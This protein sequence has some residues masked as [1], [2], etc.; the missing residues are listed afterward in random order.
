MNRIKKIMTVTLSCLFV[1]SSVSG[2]QSSSKTEK[3]NSSSQIVSDTNSPETKQPAKTSESETPTKPIY[4]I[5]YTTEMKL[6]TTI[7]T[8]TTRTINLSKSKV[9]T[10]RDSVSH[11]KQK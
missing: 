1:I 2:C 6:S 5:I 9:M 7:T 10:L 8:L 11:T 4:V 3:E